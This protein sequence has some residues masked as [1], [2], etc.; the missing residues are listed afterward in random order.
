MKKGLSAALCPR[1]L[2][3]DAVAVV[4]VQGEQRI[5]KVQHDAAGDVAYTEK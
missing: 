4:M 1:A 2:Y 5:P 3:Y